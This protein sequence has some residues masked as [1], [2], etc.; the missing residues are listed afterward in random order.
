LTPSRVAELCQVQGKITN[1]PIDGKTRLLALG[2][3][4][5]DRLEIDK[6]SQEVH[7]NSIR[8]CV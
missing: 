5:R 6:L 2:N 7:T 4:H 8:L 1:L 3:T